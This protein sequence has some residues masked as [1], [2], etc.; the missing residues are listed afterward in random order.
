MK[1][2]FKNINFL[3]F[4]IVMTFMKIQGNDSVINQGGV[5]V[6]IGMKDLT[7][8]K[9]LLNYKNLLIQGLVSDE[10]KLDTLKEEIL[11]QNIYGRVSIDFQNLSSLPYQ[12]NMVN[13]VIINDFEVLKGLGLTWEE[14]FRITTPNG[15]IQVMG[16][17]SEE[18]LQKAGFV[19]IRKK[20]KFVLGEKPRPKEMDDWTHH[21]HSPSR[22]ATSKD[23]LVGPSDSMQWIDEPRRI[24]SFP[25]AAVTA[26]GKFFYVYDYAPAFVHVALQVELVARDAF[27]GMILWKKQVKCGNRYQ[28][29]IYPGQAVVANDNFLYAPLETDGPLI[30]FDSNTGDIIKTYQDTKP[31]A[32][33]LTNTEILMLTKKSIKLLSESTG[34]IIW[35]QPISPHDCNIAVYQN[36]AFT[37]NNRTN[38]KCYDLMTGKTQWEIN[39]TTFGNGVLVGVINDSVIISGSKIFSLSVKD[40]SLTWS[41]TYEMPGRGSPVNIF[42]SQGK[43]WVHHNYEERRAGVWRA[44]NPI[45]GNISKEI[46]VI[47]QDK[48]A[49][50]TAT[51]KYLLSGRMTFTDVKSEKTF[52]P[53][54]VRAAC[55]IGSI[56]AN[57]LVYNF[58]TNC[59]CYPHIKGIMATGTLEGNL[60]SQ[61]IEKN[62]IVKG[63]GILTQIPAGENDWPIYRANNQ[64]FGSQKNNGPI[65]PKLKWAQ[66]FS[67]PITAATVANDKVFVC[68]KDQHI[69]YALQEDTGQ[70]IW[71]YN[72]SGRLISPPTY[73]NGALYLGCNDGWAYCISSND[74]KLIWKFRAGPN[75]KRII[76]YNQWESIWPLVGSILVHDNKVFLA[77]GRH[78]GLDSGIFTYALNPESGDI[79]WESKLKSTAYLDIF[80]LQDNVLRLG[81]NIIDSKTGEPISKKNTKQFLSPGISSPFDNNVYANRTSWVYEKVVGQLLTIRGENVVGFTSFTSEDLESRKYEMNTPNQGQF[82]LFTGNLEG[83]G[84]SKAVLPIRPDGIVL[85]GDIIY[86]AGQEDQYPAKQSVLLTYDLKTSKELSRITMIESPV[87]DGVIVANEKVF[88]STKEGRLICFDSKKE[89]LITEK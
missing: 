70:I 33:I 20:D 64:R 76:A 68:S 44:I 54:S 39:N 22:T 69:L 48:C 36:K 3:L 6:E 7:N 17:V 59:R 63:P 45:D 29:L 78:T 60:D 57:G 52:T 86:I 74:G 11:N 24:R 87:F 62:N 85:A 66:Q 27:N 73:Y 53:Q 21:R 79:I 58:P 83:R 1:N 50:G 23:L 12:S 89:N 15:K 19:N 47:F 35:E 31:I 30:K 80:V 55:V 18:L 37:F 43:I 14:V 88:I 13:L 72:T 75:N 61:K 71:Q 46:P 9:D 38:L 2:V 41:H 84:D 81:F 26:G 82:K 16:V 10:K 42:F 34:S 65:K 77:A 56:P 40:G 28:D 25:A 5:V 67:G 4:F 49:I 51:E 32:T 8:I